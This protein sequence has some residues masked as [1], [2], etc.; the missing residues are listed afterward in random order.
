[1]Q[2]ARNS[3]C[4]KQWTI[5]LNTNNKFYECNKNIQ[6]YSK[7]DVQRANFINVETDF[8][9]AKKQ[10]QLLWNLI[11]KKH[12]DFAFKFRKHNFA[13]CFMRK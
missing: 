10:I 1:M 13:K 9:N 12:S 4:K 6:I 2:N 11:I 8:I 7:H 3:L 5:L